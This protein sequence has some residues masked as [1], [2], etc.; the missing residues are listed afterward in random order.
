MKVIGCHVGGGQEDILEGL[1]FALKNDLG[2]VQVFIASPKV[3]NVGRPHPAYWELYNRIP[4]VIHSP[5]WVSFFSQK[6]ESHQLEFLAALRERFV[7]DIPVRYVTHLGNP[8]KDSAYK[9]QQDMIDSVLRVLEGF[10]LED[11]RVRVLLENSAGKGSLPNL[12]MESLYRIKEQADVGICLDSEH[13]FAF[14]EDLL[15]VPLECELVHLNGVP[16]YV[17]KGGMLDRHSFTTLNSSKPIIRDFIKRLPEDMPVVLERRE[18]G[19]IEQDIA[20]LR[21]RKCLS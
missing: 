14:G 12:T 9:S 2:V 19:I 6:T 10:H 15:D 17:M 20:F 8:S 3:Y 13:A 11:K 16:P 4:V 1:K 5:Y 21:G 18:F 7:R